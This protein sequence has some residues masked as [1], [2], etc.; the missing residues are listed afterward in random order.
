MT[1]ELEMY[2]KRVLCLVLFLMAVLALPT[3]TWAD[4]S[5]ST[6]EGSSIGGI[7]A[8]DVEGEDNESQ[9]QLADDSIL[10]G[11]PEEIATQSHDA[12]TPDSNDKELEDL[13]TTEP[14][15]SELIAQASSIVLT[16]S[17]SYEL[18]QALK[19]GKSLTASFS[20]SENCYVA[21]KIDAGSN[22]KGTATL[23]KVDTATKVDEWTISSDTT[24]KGLLPLHPASYELTI[25]SSNDATLI[26]AIEYQ[27]VVPTE[28]LANLEEEPNNDMSNANQLVFDENIVGTLCSGNATK[29]YEYAGSD[30]DFYSF[31]LTEPKK[32]S[33]AMGTNNTSSCFGFVVMNSEGKTVVYPETGNYAIWGTSMLGGTTVDFTSAQ[34]IDCGTLGAGAYYIEV[35]GD[36]SSQ[37]A[38]M[39][40][41]RYQFKATISKP[42]P[43]ADASY[44]LLRADNSIWTCS[45]AGEPIK[46]M[47]YDERDSVQTLLIE[48]DVQSIPERMTSLGPMSK[49][50]SYGCY[51]LFKNLRYVKFC[52]DSSGKNACTSIE[53]YAFNHCTSL[54]NVIGMENSSLVSIE[55]CAFRGCSSLKSLGLPESLCTIGERAFYNDALLNN[56]YGMESTSLILIERLAFRGCSSLR[57]LSVPKSLNIIR[58]SAFLGCVLLERIEGLDSCNL[59]SIGPESFCGCSSLTELT[60][61]KTLTTLY[62]HVFSGCSSLKKVVLPSPTVAHASY[63]DGEDCFEGSPFSTSENNGAWIHVPYKLVSAYKDMGRKNAWVRHLTAITTPINTAIVTVGNQIYNGGAIKPTVKVRLNGTTLKNGQDYNVSYADNVHVGTAT[64]TITGIR[65]YSGKCTT[66]FEIGKATPVISAT[67]ITVAK[68]KTAKVNASTIKG[69]GQFSYVSSNE[70]VAAVSSTGVV[71]GKKLGQAVI[72][73]ITSANSDCEEATK[74]VTVT[75]KYTNPLKAKARKATVAVNQSKLQAKSV[76]LASNIAKKNAK[77]KVTYSSASTKAVAKKFKINAK[78]GKVTVRKGTKKGTYIIKVKVTAAGDTKYLSGMAIVKYKVKVK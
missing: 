57:T 15:E 38:T 36:C 16:P 9:D 70:A 7:E 66:T 34:T 41:N 20:I 58:D 51:L 11:I 46:M 48:A 18:N 75:V 56:I 32:L 71:T 33:V 43:T 5:E 14:Q 73:I 12:V 72:T 49:S 1:R 64:V 4:T 45:S 25:T 23:T 30:S 76:V 78:T 54:I 47:R 53:E 52:T 28:S 35:V 60:F 68:G 63:S 2:F 10:D 26:T 50:T 21:I 13:Q 24:Y 39:A 69:A 22:S 77:G 59:I 55:E 27:Q 74:T 37:P 29:L 8:T 42:A 67:N 19:S 17:N 61:P 62:S 40:K 6:S 3:V 65:E 44:A 31:T